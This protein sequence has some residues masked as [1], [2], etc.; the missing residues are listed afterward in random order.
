V[1]RTPY[2]GKIGKVVD[3][4]APLQKLESES[5]ARVLTV[6]FEDGSQAT[7]P[8]ANVEMIEG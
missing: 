6:E 2:F 4:P 8:R 7:V 3:L 5:H 1:I